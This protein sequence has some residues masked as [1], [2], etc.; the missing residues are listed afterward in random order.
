MIHCYTTLLYTPVGFRQIT[1]SDAG[2]AGSVVLMAVQNLTIVLTPESGV[3]S[4][5]PSAL[6]NRN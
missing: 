6:L 4:L 3:L 5:P 2:L 1:D